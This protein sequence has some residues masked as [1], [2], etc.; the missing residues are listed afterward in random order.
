MPSPRVLNRASCKYIDADTHIAQAII[1][2]REH[3]MCPRSP[4][5]QG[6]KKRKATT[7]PKRKTSPKKRAAAKSS[8]PK[9]KKKT[10]KK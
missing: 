2:E 10:T 8:P 3:L 9:Q 7:S 1:A 6:G 4:Q 5:K